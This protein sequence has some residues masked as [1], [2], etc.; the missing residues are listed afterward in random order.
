MPPGCAARKRGQSVALQHDA[1]E[2]L[3]SAPPV[4]VRNLG[5]LEGDRRNF[6]FP[7]G[8]NLVREIMQFTDFRRKTF[9]Q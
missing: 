1:A 8:E 6:A 7:N 5:F 9:F 3:N 2:E 4:I